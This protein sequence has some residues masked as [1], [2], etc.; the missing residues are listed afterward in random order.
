MVQIH[1]DLYLSQ[2]F[3]FEKI[4]N[5]RLTTLVSGV[6][7]NLM[8]DFGMVF[9]KKKPDLYKQSPIF[10]LIYFKTDLAFFPCSL[11]WKDLQSSSGRYHVLRTLHQY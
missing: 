4:I 1:F 6:P 7:D 2:V 9:E 11:N 10:I 3:V 5:T 8:A